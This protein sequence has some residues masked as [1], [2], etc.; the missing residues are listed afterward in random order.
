MGYC[1]KYNVNNMNNKTHN[2][3]K[4]DFDNWAQIYDLVDGR[5]KNDI[6]FYKKEAKKVKGEVLEI[7]CGTGRIYIE[8]LK[9]GVKAQGVDISGGMLKVL[10]QKAKT[11]GLSPN[12]CVAD[13]RSL[14]MGK[15]YP[16]IIVPFRSF[17]HNL[18]IN[19]QIST[20][21]NL[22]KHLAP[23]GKIILNF[24]FPKPNLMVEGVNREWK[25]KIVIDGEE[26]EISGRQLAVD[27]VNQFS[28]SEQF[29]FKGG[30]KIWEGKSRTAYIYKR[31]FEL[32]LMLAG[33][34]NWKVYGNFEF[35]PFRD[36]AEEMVW[37]IESK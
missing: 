17:L 9:I 5:R 20:L 22:K 36:K 18:I 37:V 11:L 28:E 25:E 29:L 33:F 31:E 13:M 1:L 32:L 23:G 15:K 30:K 35:K 24:F 3:S 7:A 4:K 12:V 34:K 27:E 16:L 26:I 19:D 14:D 8:L 21:K 10:R 6:E 2:P